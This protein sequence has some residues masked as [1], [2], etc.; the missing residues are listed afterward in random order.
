MVLPKPSAFLALKINMLLNCKV[1]GF[2]FACWSFWCSYVC[3]LKVL[4]ES[5]LKWSSSQWKWISIYIDIQ[6]LVVVYTYPPSS[7]TFVERLNLE[8][9]CHLLR[10]SNSVNGAQRDDF[11]RYGSVYVGMFW[12]RRDW[13]RFGPRYVHTGVPHCLETRKKNLEARWLPLIRQFSRQWNHF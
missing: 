2:S 1:M 8:N 5:L 7:S 12:P 3:F 10:R 9:Y 13:L 11:W 6:H 4:R